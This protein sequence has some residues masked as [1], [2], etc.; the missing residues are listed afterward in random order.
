MADST[1]IDAPSEAMVWHGWGDPGR[2][3][4]LP[5]VALRLLAGRFGSLPSTLP[6]ALE[7]VRLPAPVL[8]EQARVRLSAAVGREHLRDD[9]LTRVLHAGGKSYPDLLR[10]RT[11]DA[12]HAPDAVVFP[13][14]HDEV[15]MVIAA[16]VA[17]QVAIVPFGGGTS[18]VGGVEPLRGRFAAVVALDLERMDAVIDIDAQSLTTTLQPGLRAPRAEAL[19]RAQGLSLGHF[20]QSFAYTSIG[21]MVASRSAGQASTGHGRIDDL[22][23]RLRLATPAG[24]LLAGRVER[25]ATGPDLRALLVGSEGVLGVVTEATLRV[26][27]APQ[28]ELY[29]AWLARTFEHGLEALR[30]LAQAGAEPDVA[31]LSDAAETDTALTLAGGTPARGL[32]ALLA[33]RGGGCLVVVGWDGHPAGVS[34][35]RVHGRALLRGA[36]LWPLGRGPG[37]SWAKGRF[38]GPYLRDELMDRGLLADTLETAGTWSTLPALYAAVRAALV[39]ALREDDVE[40]LVLCHASHLY[41]TG[42]SLYFT[43]VARAGEDPLARWRTAKRAATRAI[44]AAGGTI[45]HHHGVGTDH[46][47]WMRD[48]VGDLGVE[49]L[50]ALKRVLDPTG[51]L[52]PG[53]LLP[54]V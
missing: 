44:V 17:E 20:P 12:E 18:V 29:E 16:C 30:S 2:R 19:L 22:V 40:P 21:G 42:A 28:T 32:R 34:A 6:V 31:R 26:R 35:R 50:G 5:P 41:A 15:R 11:G 53:K 1:L 13:A 3:H 8:T 25:S 36:R 51:V 14:T 23:V 10:R 39:Q 27:R 37:Q 43:F 33:R 4:G 54:G 47:P 52:N 45:S 38:E 9:R 7:E 24:P 48:E 49:L 46:R